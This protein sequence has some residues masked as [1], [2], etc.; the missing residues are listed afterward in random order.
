M[1][2]QREQGWLPDL[3]YRDGHFENNLALFV[4]DGLVTRFSSSPEDLQSAHRLPRR[5][6]L[7][8]L[9]NAHSHTFQRAIRGR[10]EHRTTAARD[11]FWTWREAMYHAARQLSPED[12]G[13]VARM[14]FLEML[15]SGITAVG[16]FHYLHHAPD[17]TFH[18][19]PNLLAG[20]VLQ[21]AH[22]VG[23]RIALLKTAYA[24]SGW[25][26]APNPGQARFITPKVEEFLRHTDRLRSSLS[27][28][29]WPPQAWLGVAPHSVRAVSLPYLQEVTAYARQNGL[30]IHMHVSEQPAEIEACLAEHGL[31]PF[32]L[33]HKYN[34][35]SSNF[36][37][38]HSIHLTDEEIG[39]LGDAGARVCAC[40]TT[41]RNLGDG[42]A[43]A[44]KFA[45]S[46]VGVCYGSDS[47]IQIDL[48]EDAREL[49]YHLR[50]KHLG[51]N[52][53]APDMGEGSLARQLFANAT[54]EGAASLGAPG[55]SLAAGKAAD[56]F[57][58]DLD[59][60]SIAGASNAS[61]LSNIVFSA[62]RTAI[63]DAVVG[64]REVL[65]DGRHP[66]QVK[67]VQRFAAVQ[68]KLWG[69]AV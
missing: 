21:A 43:P 51:R 20:E 11:S 25:N 67:I 40:G 29:G 68:K 52:L 30:K 9:V 14:A 33:L 44:D 15:A 8:G 54:E 26:T 37:G 39:F 59:D 34:I 56:F 2:A 3:I 53:L 58:V 16:E 36:T 69:S 5:A 6:I 60:I 50:L 61:L 42:I 65:T 1:T 7:P 47:N 49:E 35:L 45:Q 19:D 38:V 18:D 55:G 12:I 4:S 22:D 41:E 57:T 23:L 62:E 46:G 66:L 27:Q 64:G 32:E 17:G 48:L 31:R 24:R 28:N 13:D 10:T 63:R